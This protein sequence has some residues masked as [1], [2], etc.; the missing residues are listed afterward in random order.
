MS[1]KLTELD[2]N[3]NTFDDLNAITTLQSVFVIINTVIN[4]IL[5]QFEYCLE[6]NDKTMII[7]IIMIIQILSFRLLFCILNR[8]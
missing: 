3:N 1:K 5:I 8:F 4:E 7:V 2:V 6:N